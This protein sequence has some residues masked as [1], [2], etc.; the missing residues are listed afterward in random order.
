MIILSLFFNTNKII[1][2]IFNNYFLDK[3]GVLSYSLYIWQQLFLVNNDLNLNNNN[4][5]LI[6]IIL[7]LVSIISY[8]FI[9]KPFLRKAFIYKAKY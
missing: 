5:S 4:I 3:I 1:Y 2:H 6:I 8:N 7:F 9:E